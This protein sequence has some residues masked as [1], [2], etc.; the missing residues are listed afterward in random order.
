MSIRTLGMAL[1][2]LIAIAPAVSASESG[3]DRS[4]LPD[5]MGTTNWTPP[6]VQQWTLK[7]GLAVWL[8]EVHEAPLVSLRVVTTHGAAT[9]P[10]DK[11]GVASLMVDM[12]D[13]GA[14]DR[15]ALALS[16][17][18]Q[19]LATDYGGQAYTD[20]LVFTLEM[21][22]DNVE[23]SLKLFSDVLLRP[24]F[25]QKEFE[26]RKAQRIASALAQ[27]AS[28]AYGATA[29][30]RRVLFG[31]GYGGQLTGGVRQSLEGITLD[32][33]KGRYEGLVKP[34]GGTIIIVGDTT[35][36]AI[37]ALLESTL[38][39][40]TGAPS[41]AVASAT[42]QSNLNAI[43]AVDYPGSA[44]SVISLARPTAGTD[45]EDLFA[46]LV[47]NKQFS[48]GFT[49]R[50][51]MNLREDKGYTYGA[52]GGF[53]RLQKAG[54]Y[55]IGAKVKRDTTRK[56]LDEIIKELAWVSGDKPLTEKELNAGKGGMIKSFPGR[57]ERMSSVAGQL[58]RL[59][60]D[61]YSPDW[62]A[63]WPKRVNEIDLETARSAGTK[64][65]DSTGFAI[66]VA[67]DLSKI[68]ESLKGLGRPIKL[69]DAQGNA[70]PESSD[71]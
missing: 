50:V 3:P 21:L 47:F 70:L 49:G 34:K 41:L 30:R 43:Y 18:F 16:E 45:A 51:N 26:R 55:K 2:A 42:P 4:K 24:Q 25:S 64:Y 37:N 71:K 20:G 40:W 14:G 39:E 33:L 5:P 67:G 19:L 60:V 9:D 66:I 27:E 36:T 57:F 69:F 6:E 17:A 32:D 28:P 1:I 48:G 65:T 63:A 12:M 13:E 15:S 7:N 68:G 52:R 46:T 53:E 8:L 10:V 23:A 29:V 38:G 61:G 44:Q 31:T 54:S 22:A 62:Y 58:V 35:K 11:A 56:S 59:V